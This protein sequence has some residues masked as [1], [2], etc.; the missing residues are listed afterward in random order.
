M[1][2]VR[3]PRLFWRVVWLSLGGVYFVVPLVATVEFSLRGAPGS[4]ELSA[5]SFILRDPQFQA[6]F[7]LSLLLALETAA[8]SLLLL[9]PTAYWIHVRLPQLRPALEFLSVLPFMVPPIVLVVGLLAV[10]RNAPEFFVGT[11]QV[12][13]AAYVV[14]TL[15]YAYRS[16][17]VGLRAIDVRTLTEAAQGLGATTGQILLWVILPNVR[18][19]VLSGS[20]LIFTVVMGEFTMANVMLFYTLPVYLNYIGE[21]HATPAA[22]LTVISFGIT[23]AAMLGILALER[24]LGAS[25]AQVGVR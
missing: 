13:V 20:L 12:L 15:P 17:E 2:P 10:Y 19:A 7:Q 4:Y 6:S 5:Y 25:Q 8:L 22:A 1:G 14:V 23:W 11:P 18:A 3:A 16:L 24:K 9:L 21:T